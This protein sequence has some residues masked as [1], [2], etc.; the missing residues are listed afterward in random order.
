MK[1][2]FH[3]AY[4]DYCDD[5]IMSLEYYDRNRESELIEECFRFAN[6]IPVEFKDLEIESNIAELLQLLYEYVFTRT[7]GCVRVQKLQGG[8]LKSE[9]AMKLEEALI[10]FAK[11]VINRGSEE[12]TWWH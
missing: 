3:K 7:R 11:F 4:K 1:I 5:S 9:Y 8:Y 12:R 10:D 2:D 6:Q